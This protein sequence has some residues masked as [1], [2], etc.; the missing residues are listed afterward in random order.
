VNILLPANQLFC[1]RVIDTVTALVITL[2]VRVICNSD[3]LI[4]KQVTVIPAVVV[5]H[6]KLPSRLID[7]GKLNNN[8]SP[9]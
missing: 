6:W 8:L 1:I 4:V 9:E 2:T 3:E 5:V 7:D